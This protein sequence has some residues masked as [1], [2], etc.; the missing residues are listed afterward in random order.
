MKRLLFT[1]ILSF[2]AVSASAQQTS[3]TFMPLATSPLF[4]SR[5]TYNIVLAAPLVET[6]AATYTQPAGDTHPVTATC[7]SLRVQLA[8]AVARNPSSY[9]QIFAVHLVTSGNINLAGALTGTAGA[10][11]LDTPATDGALFSAINAQWSDVAGC[12]TVP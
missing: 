3:V 4:Q 5:V 12:V 6:E 1:L 11:T 8:V 10:G 7:H 9:A 2:A